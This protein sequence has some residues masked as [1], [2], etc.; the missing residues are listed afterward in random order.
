MNH[1][2]VRYFFAFEDNLIGQLVP[3]SASDIHPLKKNKCMNTTVRNFSCSPGPSGQ[4]WQYTSIR[5]RYTD[6]RVPRIRKH[7]YHNS[8]HRVPPS[9]GYCTP[10]TSKAGLKSIHKA[11]LA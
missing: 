2:Y 6:L 4:Q 10:C 7:T 9:A 1:A 8:Y 11:G 5:R 3:S